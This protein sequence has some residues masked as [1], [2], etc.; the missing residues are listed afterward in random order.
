MAEK[1]TIEASDLPEPY[2]QF[3]L[4]TDSYFNHQMLSINNLKEARKVF[5]KEFIKHSLLKNENNIRKTA[6]AIGID[7]SSL[8]KKIKKLGLN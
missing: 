6:D 8:H 4:K 7:R 2:N 1:D 5:E 3:K